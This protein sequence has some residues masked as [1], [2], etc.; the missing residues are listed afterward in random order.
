MAKSELWHYCI[1]ATIWQ[2]SLVQM[3][4]IL[5]DILFIIILFILFLTKFYF[6]YLTIFISFYLYFTYSYLRLCFCFVTFYI[7]YIGIQTILW[8][9]ITRKTVKHALTAGLWSRWSRMFLAGVGVGSRSRF[10]KT[11]GVGVG[12]RSRESEHL[13]QLPTPMFIK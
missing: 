12:S 10:F 11:A 6:F 5:N 8:R 4:W 13:L 3:T 9:P 2:H 1:K 7:L